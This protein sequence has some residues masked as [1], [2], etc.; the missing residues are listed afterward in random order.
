MC[1]FLTSLCRCFVINIS[2][3]NS[4]PTG[5]KSIWIMGKQCV[6]SQDK[7]S[8]KQGMLFVFIYLFLV[9]SVCTTHTALQKKQGGNLRTCSLSI[10]HSVFEDFLTGSNCD[11]KERCLNLSPWPP[12]VRWREGGTVAEHWQGLIRADER[13]RRLRWWERV[14]EDAGK[15]RRLWWSTSE[16]EACLA[17]A[18]RFKVALHACTWLKLNSMGFRKGSKV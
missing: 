3:S 5:P 12:A 17:H 1:S 10:T 14:R 18:A 9:Q 11:P 16:S 2:W 13:N 7:T 6:W 15:P 4:F 8:K